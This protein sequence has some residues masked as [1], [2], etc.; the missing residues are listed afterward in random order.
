MKKIPSLPSLLGDFH[1]HPDA[2][3]FLTRSVYM[4]Q[5]YIDFDKTKKAMKMDGEKAKLDNTKKV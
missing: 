3:F 4:N 5:I 2:A 1:L